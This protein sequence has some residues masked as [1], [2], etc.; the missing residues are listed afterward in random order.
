VTA[1]QARY[2]AELE[3]ESCMRWIFTRV[4]VTIMNVLYIQSLVA[5]ENGLR[6]ANGDRGI[7]LGADPRSVGQ[8][9][10]S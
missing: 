10:E 9:S 8:L 1:G 4:I 7:P 5:D 2:A 6:R 3:D